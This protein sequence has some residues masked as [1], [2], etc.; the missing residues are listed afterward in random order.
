[1]AYLELVK[2]NKNNDFEESFQKCIKRV[3]KLRS[4]K[5]RYFG[6]KQ[7]KKLQLKY[8]RTSIEDIAPILTVWAGDL[9]LNAYEYYKT[10]EYYKLTNE[11]KN[12]FKHE[13]PKE[14]FEESVYFYYSPTGNF[15]IW[16][17]S[18]E[19]SSF[20]IKTGA[21]FSDDEAYKLGAKGMNLIINK[22][23]RDGSWF[24]GET[25]VMKYI[26]NFHTA[27]ILRAIN[28]S[29]KYLKSKEL[30]HSLNKGLKY[31]KSSFFINRGENLIQPRHFINK[32]IP[33]NSNIIQKIDIRDCALSIILFSEL[34]NMK[35]EISYR[36]LATYIINWSN[37][38]MFE[39]TNYYAEKTWLWTNKIPYI[40]FQAW[41]L[42]A[43]VKYM[44][45]NE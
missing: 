3:K 10:E 31:Y 45:Y 8:Y 44:N 32:N 36:E 5:S 7:G 12:Y 16:N 25:K 1:M 21:I 15:K 20:L 14:F 6:V 35:N 41:M 39:K 37:K 18:C 2:K 42:L 40:D 26:D 13:H 38:E 28:K 33:L 22:Q 19:I 34:S 17:A 24:Y 30:E 43:I 29:L 11:I 9:F 27:F 23:N 4:S